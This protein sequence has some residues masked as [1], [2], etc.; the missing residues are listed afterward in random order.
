MKTSKILLLVW[1]LAG[2]VLLF[3]ADVTLYVLILWLAGLVSLVWN[4]ID[5]RAKA[6]RFTVNGPSGVGVTL[7]SEGEAEVPED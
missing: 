3:V 2:G 5:S 1:L 7:S 6:Y 4:R